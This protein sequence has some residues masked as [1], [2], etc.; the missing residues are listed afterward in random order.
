MENPDNQKPCVVQTPQ[1]FSISYKEHLL[2]SKYNPSKA[3]IQTVQNLQLLPGSIILCN[4]PVL[5]YGLKELSEKLPDNCIIVLCEAEKALYDY[6]KTNLDTSFLEKLLFPEPE[7][8]KNLPL[9]L[10]DL[11]K[12]GNYKRVI[13]INFSAGIQF[14]EDFYKSLSQACT[15]SVMTFWKN[16]ITL[17][18]FGRRYSQN[19][20]SNL[21]NLQ[22]SLPVRNYFHA[23]TKPILVFG[24][25]Q[26]L[27]LFIK[28]TNLNYKDFFVLCVDTALKPL[29]KH[30]IKP[31][32]V[33]LEEAQSI[34]T[35]SFITN[36]KDIHFFAGLSST[37]QLSHI[38]KV[39]N[40]SYFMTEYTQGN[41]TDKLYK[42]IPQLEKNPPFGSVGLTAVYYALK[43]RK[44][45]SIPVYT[46]GLDFSFSAGPTHA[47]ESISHLQ[48]LIQTN[49]LKAID[50]LSAA[51]APAN[52]K[53]TDKS[54][55]QFFTSPNLA[56]YA[57]LF[58]Q[59]FCKEKNLFDSS[60]CGIPLNITKKLPQEG[61]SQNIE[62]PNKA[63]SDSE[64]AKIK[65]YLNK[66]KEELIKLSDI[67]KGRTSIEVEKLEEEIKKRISDKEYLY[68]HFADGSRFN[69][70]QSFLNRIS[71]EISFFLKWL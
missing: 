23:I 38:T 16:R 11:C 52:R 31:D 26:S 45:D 17:T 54:G 15:N 69:Y 29:L 20:F 53:F 44:D 46:T 55:N 58:N 56:S 43:F 27:D 24:A 64:K 7:T 4:S 19:L 3:I 70:N 41:F 36:L 2:Y 10:Y 65:E 63:F 39:S 66:E 12:T 1:G 59:Y 62:I 61:L 5:T 40:I 68:L 9:K 33:F 13:S 71:T 49:R 47:K 42:E 22:E 50:N 60:L 48:R 34:I 30:G 8:L 25:G 6:E 21:K 67:L 35:K 18:K 32:G 14:H 51:F 37:R 28:N 57:E